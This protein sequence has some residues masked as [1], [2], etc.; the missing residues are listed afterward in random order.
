MDESNML[1]TRSANPEA[2]D[3][4]ENSRPPAPTLP[5]ARGRTVSP[6]FRS[7]AFRNGLTVH[8]HHQHMDEDPKLLKA[9]KLLVKLQSVHGVVATNFARLSALFMES[10]HALFNDWAI[11]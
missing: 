8:F 7:A 6:N 10:F 2:A 3:A 11:V 1:P 4:A 5:S 9:F